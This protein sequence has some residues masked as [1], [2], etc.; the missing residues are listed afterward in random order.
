[1]R[2]ALWLQPYARV[3]ARWLSGSDVRPC[4]V[5]AAEDAVRDVTWAV[6]T[7]ARVVPVATCLVQALAA[8]R[9]LRRRGVVPTLRIGVP[10]RADGAF[11]AHAWLAWEGR[12][13]LG[14][15]EDIDR[16]SVLP[17]LPPGHR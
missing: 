8:E 15:R 7:A 10:P 6:G 11:V 9:M 16:Y 14:D 13:V 17:D 12:I 5:V 4:E 1:M 3:R 2:A